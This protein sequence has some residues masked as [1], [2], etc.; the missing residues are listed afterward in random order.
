VLVAH[1]SQLHPVPDGYSDEQAVLIEPMACAVH[2]A[3]RAGIAPGD[4]V[5]VSGAGSVGL[6][7]TLAIRALT[8]AGEITV[9][10][11]HQHQG[12]HARLLG[13]TEVVAPGETLRRLR[14]ATGAFLV[15]PELGSSYLLGGVDVAVDAVGS[16][17]SLET[18]LH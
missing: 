17:R 16:R 14:R 11:K 2:T 10:A 4:R 8:G 12:D 15:E 13:A 18:S 9:V 3:L 1:R 6:L 5:L 7:A